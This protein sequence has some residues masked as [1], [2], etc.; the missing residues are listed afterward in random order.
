[1]KELKKSLTKLKNLEMKIELK[2]WLY[3]DDQE[4]WSVIEGLRLES[5]VYIE[6]A[7]GY[8]RAL[9]DHPLTK[10]KD[11]GEA[12]NLISTLEFEQ[13]EHPASFVFIGIPA[14][15]VLEAID[16]DGHLDEGGG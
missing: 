2:A 8:L 13:H 16:L 15:A 7:K 4:E 5:N 10:T 14:I 11:F 9:M 12:Y 6:E 3:A 1:M